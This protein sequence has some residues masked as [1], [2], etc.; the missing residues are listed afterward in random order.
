VP[1]GE[2]TFERLQAIKLPAETDDDTLWRVIRFHCVT[3]LTS[4]INQP[5]QAQPPLSPRAMK[6]R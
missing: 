1:I 5:R 6:F 2:A 4:T 3:S